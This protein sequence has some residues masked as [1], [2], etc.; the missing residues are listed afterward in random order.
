MAGAADGVVVA[1]RDGLGPD[2]LRQLA[3]ATRD[4]LG[5]DGFVI[6]L[7]VANGKAGVV[8]AVGKDR[9]AQGVSAAEL[10]APVAKLLGGG[11]AKNPELVVG[12]GPNIAAIDDALEVAREQ[13][14]RVIG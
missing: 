11:T 6:V 8:V 5:A 9:V 14:A 2:D 4:A 7:G 1:R 12:G 13:A 3:V 10:A